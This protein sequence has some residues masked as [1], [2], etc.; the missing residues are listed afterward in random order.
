MRYKKRISYSFAFLLSVLLINNSC[1]LSA[2]SKISEKL[3]QKT[4]KVTQLASGENKMNFATRDGLVQLNG[5]T[6]KINSDVHSDTQNTDEKITRPNNHVLTPLPEKAI[7]KLLSV[8]PKQAVQ[9]TAPKFAW[10]EGSKPPPQA[11]IKKIENWQPDKAPEVPVVLEPLKVLNATPNGK[12]SAGNSLQIRFSQ[13]IYALGQ[14]LVELAEKH[15]TIK[16]DIKGDYTWLDTRTLRFEAQ[17]GFAQAT[18]YTVK[19]GTSLKSHSGNQ[20]KAPYSFKFKTPAVRLKYYFPNTN[21][22]VS[23]TPII[24]LNFSVPVDPAS[25]L[26]HVYLKKQSKSD[27]KNQTTIKLRLATEKDLAADPLF[28]KLRPDSNS[29]NPIALVPLQ[30]L[31]KGSS[32]DV[33][34]L[35]GIK[36]KVGDIDSEEA[37]YFSITVEKDFTFLKMT[38][39]YSGQ[40]DCRPQDDIIVEFSNVLLDDFKTNLV[41]QS[42]K[43]APFSIFAD[44]D[45]QK[46][47]DSNKQDK[48]IQ[49]TPA[50]D[51]MQI[52]VIENKIHIYGNKQAKTRYKV[53]IHGIITDIFGNKFTQTK[54][55][56]FTTSADDYWGESIVAEPFVVIPGNSRSLYTFFTNRVENVKV[57][58]YKVKP[59]DFNQYFQFANEF[60]KKHEGY[61]QSHVS[62][63]E[64]E[65][66]KL[67]PGQLVY[68][69]Q[70]VIDNPLEFTTHA[71]KLDA[72]FQNDTSG[73]SLGHAMVVLRADKPRKNRHNPDGKVIWI[74]KT[75]IGLSSI[76]DAD[77]SVV[78]TSDITTG[79]PI[80]NVKIQVY[81]QDV[82]ATSDSSGIANLKRKK[83]GDSLA[84]IASKEADIALLPW[85]GSNLWLYKQGARLVWYVADDRNLYRPGEK[86]VFKG[87]LRDYTRKN[88]GQLSLLKADGKSIEYII[89]DSQNRQIGK[90]KTKLTD[91]NGF[92]VEFNLP[93][94]MNLGRC[95]IK[96]KL[97]GA[98]TR[99]D[100]YH[101]FRVEEFRRPEFEVLLEA[102]TPPETGS[103]KIQNPSSHIVGQS[104]SFNLTAKYFAG[105]FL[106]N[107]P[108]EWNAWSKKGYFTPPNRQSYFFGQQQAWWK[109]SHRR[110]R[111]QPQEAFPSGYSLQA[112]TDNNG[113]AHLSFALS[114]INSNSP[115]IL[116]L[117]ASVSDVN[118]QTF[119]GA[120]SVLIHPSSQYVGIKTQSQFYN[121]GETLKVESIVVDLEGKLLSKQSIK[122][123]IYAYNSS[124]VLNDSV[125]CQLISSNQAQLCQAKMD[126]SG[127]YAI[128]ASTQDKQGRVHLAR[129]YIWVAGANLPGESLDQQNIQLIGKTE[130]LHQGDELRVMLQ[131]PFAPAQVML[132]ILREGF[133][134]KRMIAMKTTSELVSIHLDQRHS[135]GFELRV[136]A[137]GG[138][139]KPSYATGSQI[140]KVTPDSEIFSLKVSTANKIVSPGSEVELTIKAANSQGA[141]SNAEVAIFVVDEAVLATADYRIPDPIEIFYQFRDSGVSTDELRDYIKIPPTAEELEDLDV[142]MTEMM[143]SRNR[144][145][146][147]EKSKRA[148]APSL[149]ADQAGKGEISIRKSFSALALFSPKTQTNDKG[150]AKIKFTLPDSL[151]RY[152][153]TAIAAKDATQF[154]YGEN[155][156]TAQLS[157]MLRPMPPRFSNVGDHFELPVV[158]Q[159]ISDKSIQTDIAL[160][161]QNLYAENANQK[162]TDSKNVNSL[163]H[164][165]FRIEVPA[166][167][168]V[169]VRFPVKPKSPGVAEGDI[170]IHGDDHFDAAHFSFPVWTPLAQESEAIYGEIVEGVHSYPVNFPSN[171]VAGFGGINIQTSSTA[172]N[173]LGDAYLYLRDYPYSCSEQIASRVL[174]VSAL[175]SLLDNLDAAKSESKAE[176]L[177]QLKRDVKALLSRQKHNGSFGLWSQQTAEHSYATIHVIHALFYAKQLN[178]EVDP[179]Q[180]KKALNYLQN[181]DSKVNQ[182]HSP[183][184][185]QVIRAY[186]L[187][188]ESLFNQSQSNQQ[189]S[190]P[191]QF[192]AK[193]KNLFSE[194]KPKLETQ[195]LA[196]I[197]WLL[198]ALPK[199]DDFKNM[200]EELINHIANHTD[201]TTRSAHVGNVYTR[202]GYSHMASRRKNDALVLSALIEHDTGSQ[203]INKFMRGLMDKRIKGRWYNTQENVFVL[204]AAL[205]YFNQFEKTSPNF[206]AST[207]L[208]QNFAGS[209]SF[210]QRNTVTKELMIPESLIESGNQ[211]LTISKEG[212][213]RLYYRIG[214]NYA[215]DTGRIDGRSQGFTVTRSFESVG[216]DKNT[217]EKSAGIWHIKAGSLVRV[218]LTMKVPGQRYYVALVDPIAAGLEPLNPSL[219]NTATRSH[220]N[221]VSA[222][223]SSDYWSRN[224]FS[225]QNL[226]DERAEAFADQLWGGEFKYSYLARA[227]TLG[228]FIVPPARAE[229][230]YNP[231]TFG[232]SASDIIIVE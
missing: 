1:S 184:A 53:S 44:D 225:H 191:T 213:G 190:N 55:A 210:K 79:K 80:E 109:F 148:F 2:G 155:T 33:H 25:L 108:V 124:G 91:L 34:L 223:Q 87:W 176:R 10:R 203:L 88:N 84:I 57:Q 227:T 62:I 164:Q 146:G 229:E 224:W 20:L 24:F 200:R 131:T 207:W 4:S 169:E 194:M 120:T 30:V 32:Y 13:D 35:A 145:L 197:A 118:R 209:S 59:Q 183:Q 161:A 6:V 163:M 177:S 27:T 105:G 141:V 147:A 187:Y 39:G 29:E 216:D 214:I 3:V 51:G 50:I 166:N 230:M 231:E 48:R 142:E 127:I 70:L 220:A 215:L 21:Q 66:N 150:E 58:I 125:E 69:S 113:E 68:E 151:T 67:P 196:A 138:G 129:Q 143:L 26:E 222:N 46:V 97:S 204:L 89:T 189:L 23:Q 75:N 133:I 167:D 186:A 111:Y 31:Q 199:Q 134:E 86:I 73:N 47:K 232:R 132:S 128:E 37:K 201:Q 174:A 221:L 8:L 122:I 114:S 178:I 156:I 144:D 218:T 158:I 170:V 82:V 52:H 63:I 228:R 90:G 175:G 65:S 49:I 93:Q 173:T 7:E 121:R 85:S 36:P 168:R 226:R 99:N 104:V 14:Q 95:I 198:S 38:C 208:G 18:N 28:S 42:T 112:Q 217:V 96:F 54:T 16:P 140:Y 185:K 182:Y 115:M 206:V 106:A 116:D 12:I 130:N 149:Q 98:S 41:Q 102:E 171:L 136:Q 100:Y 71:L 107:A 17:P 205:K 152:R 40:Q 123:K 154:A 72:A 139:D 61:S 181:I 92:N 165:G 83:H 188:V 110:Y 76:N 22:S 180:L 19:I 126:T 117:Q 45:T 56:R 153:I 192:A 15:I 159:N 219:A 195:S 101:Y 74:E 160:R 202:G 193:A 11:E 9:Q 64:N 212:E 78:L 43:P 172:L 179:S 5:L 81:G 103:Q 135:P 94:Q 60:Y 157:L 137:V 119:N 162:N 77:Q 211:P